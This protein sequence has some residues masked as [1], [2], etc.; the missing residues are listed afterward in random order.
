M[1]SRENDWEQ[2]DLNL[3]SARMRADID[4][5]WG[6]QKEPY[7]IVIQ[8]KKIKI[9]RLNWGNMWHIIIKK[10]NMQSVNENVFLG[11]YLS[12]EPNYSEK[13]EIAKKV[14]PLFLDAK[15]AV[16][17]FPPQRSVV[18]AANLYHLWTF[19][20][21][22]FPFEC[23]FDIPEDNSEEWT[24]ENIGG[25]KV[26]YASK[27]FKTSEGRCA[28][29][30]IRRTDGKELIWREKQMLKNKIYFEGDTSTAIELIDDFGNNKNA[31]CLIYLPFDYNLDF[32][33]V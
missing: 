32:G 27:T 13:L 1:A 7:Q 21:D 14:V 16:E 9:P 8:I 23:H 26:E 6:W 4:E 2:I 33:L 10:C 30:W 20:K 22:K 5:V 28:C 19:D 12:E 29:T 15:L 17:V 11:T 3:L 24:K 25:L 31:T 18:D